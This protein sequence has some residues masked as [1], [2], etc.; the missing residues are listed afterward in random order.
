M[1]KGLQA[2]HRV[3]LVHAD[4]EPRHLGIAVNSSQCLGQIIDVGCFRRIG[5]HVDILTYSGQ[6][7]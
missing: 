7:P 3:G 2:L 4:L 1:L 5:T 6:P